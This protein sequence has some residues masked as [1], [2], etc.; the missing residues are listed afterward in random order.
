M[1]DSQLTREG[2]EINN[3]M[4]FED[5]TD[6]VVSYEA[7]DQIVD[8][9][10]VPLNEGEHELK[11]GKLKF[12]IEAARILRN[13]HSPDVDEKNVHLSEFITI[14]TVSTS[15][16]RA[17][18][19]LPLSEYCFRMKTVGNSNSK[20]SPIFS[21]K[22]PEAPPAPIRLTI[23]DVQHSSV[24]VKWDVLPELRY[25]NQ[26]YYSIWLSKCESRTPSPA[27]RR[28]SDDDNWFEFARV[29]VT[30]VFVT[31][32]FIGTPYRLFIR[33]HSTFG[34]SLKSNI[35]WFSTL[36]KVEQSYSHGFVSCREK[37]NDPRALWKPSD[38]NWVYPNPTSTD[39]TPIPFPTVFHLYKNG[40]ILKNSVLDQLRWEQTAILPPFAVSFTSQ[41]RPC[42][43][44]NKSCN[45]INPV[46]GVT[47]R[48]RSESAASRK[49]SRIPTP[50]TS[51]SGSRSK[52][53]SILRPSS[54]AR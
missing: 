54:A 39:S 42:E 47:Q 18:L 53:I 30:G 20:L 51:F 19:F 24:L 15:F 12:S 31:N 36:Q 48:P 9:V 25:H 16:F 33:S 4:E 10:G 38:Y 37:L 3:E 46:D 45:F 35:I 40:V 32:L 21:F 14:S 5:L 8:E 17:K 1:F 43:V 27:G 29:R 34:K 6:I 49:I 13:R 41:N 28:I 44:F 23:S 7:N 22:I 11:S 52:R 50:P 26:V 2:N